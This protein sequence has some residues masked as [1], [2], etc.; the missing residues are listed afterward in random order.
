VE[1]VR[2]ERMNMKTV[3]MRGWGRDNERREKGI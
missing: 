2:D 1:R 3:A